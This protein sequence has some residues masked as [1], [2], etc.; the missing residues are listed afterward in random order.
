MYVDRQ[1]D[2]SS[3]CASLILGTG[4]LG[5]TRKCTGAWG[6]TSLKARHCNNIYY[7]QTDMLTIHTNELYNNNKNKKN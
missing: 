4:I 6:F 3:S 2:A 5:I 7:I 1:T